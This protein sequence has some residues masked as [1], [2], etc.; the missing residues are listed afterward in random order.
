MKYTILHF[1]DLHLDTSFASTGLPVSI[2]AWRR[3]DLQATL[4]RILTIARER[5]VNAVTIGGDLYEQDY[6]LPDTGEFLVQEFSK[7]APIRIFITPGKS[8]PYTSESLYSLTRWPE[9]MT[10]FS[11]GALTAHSGVSGPPGRRNSG[12]PVHQG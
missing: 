12:V 9:N 7:A 4:S 10:T 6:A 1:A 11:Q 5:R 8:D 3:H 2:S